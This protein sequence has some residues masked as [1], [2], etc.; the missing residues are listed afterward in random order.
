M[1]KVID[2]ISES[3]T[4]VLEEGDKDG[5][6]ILVSITYI[7]K[8]REKDNGIKLTRTFKT[9]RKNNEKSNI[10]S[11]LV[12]NDHYFIQNIEGSRVAINELVT[13][14]TNE[15][16]HLL[17]HIIDFEEIETRRWNGFLIKYLI[18]GT[19]NEE[20]ALKSFSAGTDFNPYMMKKEQ[21]TDFMNTVF[22][23]KK[24]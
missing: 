4:E 21:I 23:E 20:Y 9:A 16:P 22:E 1:H 6:D 8:N 15:R 10:T 19:K 11:A 17:V 13:R 12:I 18:S 14:V 2:Y 3:G 5:A 24:P 7:G